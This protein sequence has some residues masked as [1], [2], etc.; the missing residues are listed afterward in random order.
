MAKCAIGESHSITVSNEGIAYSFGYNRN[1][2]LGYEMVNVLKPTVIPN[3]PKIEMVSCGGYFTALVDYEGFMWTFGDNSF[4]QLGTGN[5]A[6]CSKVPQKITNIPPVRS[7][8][9]GGYHTLL[10]TNDDILWSM[11]RNDTGQLFLKHSNSISK[12]CQT[13]YANVARICAGG[14]HSFFQTNDLEIF[15]CGNNQFGQ[16]GCTEV[17]KFEVYRIA[18]QDIIQISCGYYN[19]LFLNRDGDV[20]GAGSNRYGTRGLGD[21]ADPLDSITRI[22]KI[23]PMQEISCT[24]HFC[25]LLDFDG[26]VWSFGRNVIGQL[27][28]G[29]TNTRN[30]P[31]KIKS[32]KNIKHI[33]SNSCGNHF[34]LKDNENKIFTVGEN[35]LGQLGTNGVPTR[36]A[37]LIELSND[38]IWGDDHYNLTSRAKS[39]RK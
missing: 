19:S 8:S 39:A 1:G 28:H 10:I 32:T 33:T 6:G 22:P 35:S 37:T 16:L 21:M 14:Y 3:L 25:Y 18:V 20:F 30:V 9:C 17:K 11:G 34:F 2:E 31:T 29:D 12:P 15:G 4:G 38:E 27:G 26:N 24:G 23:P 5:T 36:S 7:I 13:S